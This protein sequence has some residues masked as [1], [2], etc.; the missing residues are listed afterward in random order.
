[1]TYTLK[2]KMRCNIFQ[3]CFK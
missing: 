2:K 1:V 3:L